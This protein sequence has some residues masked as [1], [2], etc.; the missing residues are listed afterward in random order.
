MFAWL[1]KFLSAFLKQKAL[2]GH[3]E[4]DPDAARLENGWL[5]GLGVVRYPSVRH[6]SSSIDS[7]IGIVWH[8]TATAPGTAK[9]LAKRIQKFDA[10]KDRA[11]SWHFLVATDGVIY[12]SVSVFEGAWHCKG[13]LEYDGSNFRVNGCTIGIEL[14]GFGKVFTA[15]QTKSALELAEFLSN[16]FHMDNECVKFKHSQFDPKRRSDPGPIWGSILD[17]HFPSEESAKKGSN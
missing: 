15:A 13:S 5:H 11:A 8:Y 3:V 1:R 7:P 9:S 10:K 14:E 4:P 16:E 17:V 2:T 12:Q 6:S